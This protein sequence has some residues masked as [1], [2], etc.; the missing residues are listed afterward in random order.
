MVLLIFLDFH[1]SQNSLN[2]L[3]DDFNDT[4]DDE[5]DDIDDTLTADYSSDEDARSVSS[6]CSI[7]VA[8]VALYNFDVCTVYAYEYCAHI[9]NGQ[10]NY[11]N[12]LCSCR[13]YFY[14]PH[15]SIFCYD[16]PPS[17]PHKKFLLGELQ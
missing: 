8:C 2:S 16:P 10:V 9:Q 5:W 7:P 14:L 12:F 11:V 15:I 17:P 3:N 6:N 1:G 4:F 13:R